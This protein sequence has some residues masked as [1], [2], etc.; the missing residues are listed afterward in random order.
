MPTPGTRLPDGRHALRCG[1]DDL[2]IPQLLRGQRRQVL[3]QR[4]P[5][6]PRRRRGRRS[7][8]S[9]TPRSWPI[10][11][12]V[13]ADL[14]FAQPNRRCGRVVTSSSSRT[15][16]RASTR[17]RA[18]GS[19]WTAQTGRPTGSRRHGPGRAWGGGHSRSPPSRMG[20]NINA[21]CGA[22]HP[23]NVAQTVREYRADL[24]I[25]LDGDA[26]RVI[27]A[28]EDGSI[29]E[30]GSHA[31]DVCRWRCR[32]AARLC[33]GRC[34]GDGHEQP[35]SRAGSGEVAGLAHRAL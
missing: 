27:M 15:H 33:A 10:E 26:D 4:R 16:F 28:A 25:A 11:R 17:W 8:A 13:G 14:G 20:L 3:L 18:C 22:L 5:Q 12:P 30:R 35:R 24:G 21:G 34:R 23:Q 1:R 19:P 31:G 32:S 9:S 29:V 7:S 2:R 6:A